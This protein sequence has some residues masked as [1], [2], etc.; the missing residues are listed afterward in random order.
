MSLSWGHSD[1]SRVL[2]LVCK[3]TKE[4]SHGA[5]GSSFLLFLG[6]KR[7]N[8]PH[9]REKN[10]FDP[11]LCLT[12]RGLCICH[13]F[14]ASPLRWPGR[15]LWKMEILGLLQATSAWFCAQW[16]RQPGNEMN[17]KVLHPSGP[18]Q[19]QQSFLITPVWVTTEPH[20]AR[21]QIV[22]RWNGTCATNV[23][24]TA[25]IPSSFTFCVFKVLEIDSTIKGLTWERETQFKPSSTEPMTPFSFRWPQKLRE[26]KQMSREKAP[27][28]CIPRAPLQL[29][30]SLKFG[31]CNNMALSP[32]IKVT[33]SWRSWACYCSQL[34]HFS[35]F[36][37]ESF[38]LVCIVTIP[39]THGLQAGFQ[40]VRWLFF[41]THHR[42]FGLHSKPVAFIKF[43]ETNKQTTIS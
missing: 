36:S 27:E 34:T 16:W 38:P 41:I 29:K 25:N 24:L 15:T 31:L 1:L 37:L 39:P 42:M 17:S 12:G 11:Q 8:L 19:C 2:E 4:F 6:T 18:T 26:Q 40:F 22:T 30:L 14:R 3:R 21:T 23:N 20:W 13:D 10:G 33:S 5:S 35:P 43:P 28:L 9:R 32:F 7:E